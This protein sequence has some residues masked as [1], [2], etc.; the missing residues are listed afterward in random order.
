MIIFLTEKLRIHGVRLVTHFFYLLCP[1]AE[2]YS[3]HKTLS[4]YKLKITVFSA[5]IFVFIERKDE[6][7]RVKTWMR[8]IKQSWQF[9]RHRSILNAVLRK[10]LAWRCRQTPSN[11]GPKFDHHLVL[12]RE[13]Q[14]DDRWSLLG[15]RANPHGVPTSQGTRTPPES[16]DNVTSHSRN[17]KP[18]TR[19][20]EWHG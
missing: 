16:Y 10:P 3:R 7:G 1:S 4:H 18:L 12:K 5:Q 8:S 19:C 14:N 17:I 15:S 6:N 11:D 13:A 9:V 2:S 20:E